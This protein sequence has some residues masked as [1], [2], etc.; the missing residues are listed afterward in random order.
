MAPGMHVGKERWKSK[1]T[2]IQE[3]SA[4]KE[5]KESESYS[6]PKFAKCGQKK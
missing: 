4:S 6:V 3:K 5:K 2:M 1:G